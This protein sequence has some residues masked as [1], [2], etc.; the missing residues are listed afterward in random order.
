MGPINV[1]D[2]PGGAVF[3]R[4]PQPNA[5]AFEYL[6]VIFQ[7]ARLWSR[8]A[9]VTTIQPMA[10]TS[11]KEAARNAFAGGEATGRQHQKPGHRR[12]ISRWR[13]RAPQAPHSVAMPHAS[14]SRHDEWLLRP[15]PQRACPPGFSCRQERRV[16]GFF[17]CDAYSFVTRPSLHM[18]THVEAAPARNVLESLIKSRA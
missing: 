2:K 10:L 9:L 17:V 6:A 1:M 12:R 13:W 5:R 11:R 3:N 15:A 18:S 4:T 14:A 8:R 16:S 7:S